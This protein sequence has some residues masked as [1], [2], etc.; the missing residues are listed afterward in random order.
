MPIFEVLLINDNLSSFI[1]KGSSYSEL[2]AEAEKT[3]F[4]TMRY[5][6]LRKVLAGITTIDEVIRVT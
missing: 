3:G 6:G 4:T 2:K 1:H 5:D